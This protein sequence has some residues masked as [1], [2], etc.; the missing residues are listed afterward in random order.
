MAQGAT[1]PCGQCGKPAVS[2]VCNVPLCVD[3]SYKFA[4]MQTLLLRN[5]AIGAN[6][7]AAEMDFI[8]GLRNFTPRMQVPEIPKAPIIMHNIHIADSVV[9]SINTGTVQTVDVS[10]TYLKQAGNNEVAEALRQLTEAIANEPSLLSDDKNNLLDQV[11]YLSDQASSAAKD[12]K[13]GMIKAAFAAISQGA[14]TVTA[15]A[16]AWNAAAPLLQ[17]LFG[18]L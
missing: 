18:S 11:A 13:R 2:S 3:C 9:G 16:A 10:I 12:R 6:H 14:G 17:T 7:A 4:V 1:Q 5:A 15:I 8:T